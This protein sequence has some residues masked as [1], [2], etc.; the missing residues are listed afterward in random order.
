MATT[1][2]NVMNG[3]LFYLH[4]RLPWGESEQD[5]EN[6]QIKLVCKQFP[7]SM[8]EGVDRA[9]SA[10]YK[11]LDG[12]SLNFPVVRGVR[13]V[14]SRRKEFAQTLLANAEAHFWGAFDSMEWQYDALVERARQNLGSQFKA[15]D[16][17][18]F[19][20]LRARARCK[21]VVFQLAEASGTSGGDL[22]GL[23]ELLGEF[24]DKAYRDLTSG[25]QE[26]VGGMVTRLLEGKRFRSASM[27]KFGEFLGAFGDL[28]SAVQGSDNYER[29]MVAF[30]AIIKQAEDCVKGIAPESL[31]GKDASP[32]RESIGTALAGV[33]QGLDRMMSMPVGAR[34]LNLNGNAEAR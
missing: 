20:T 33:A 25:L 17:P 31:Q 32:V 4:V 18:A 28:A 10:F 21:A 15:R 13:F 29:D 12:I 24:R 14:P 6:E 23:G 9:K 7:P 2:Q 16:Y 11:A 34:R 27:E 1:Q 22:M 8:T 19:S 30:Q 5:G 3:D 26:I